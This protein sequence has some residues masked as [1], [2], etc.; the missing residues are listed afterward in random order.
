VGV[1]NVPGRSRLASLVVATAGLVLAVV[2]AVLMSQGGG[3]QASAHIPPGTDTPTVTGAPPTDHPGLDFSI[4][5]NTDGS[6]ATGDQRPDGLGDPRGDDCVSFSKLLITAT[7]AAVAKCNVPP[8]ATFTVSVYVTNLGGV[9]NYAGYDAR[10]NFAGVTTVGS[11]DP[12]V[13]PDCDLALTNVQPDHVI[14]G[15][16]INPP[17]VNDS[18]HVGRIATVT[19]NCAADGTITMVHGNGLTTLTQAFPTPPSD[20]HSELGATSETLSINCDAPTLTP[21]NTPT[22]TNTPVTPTNTPTPTNTSQF[23]NTPTNTFT[24]TA[25]QTPFPEISL[26]AK[27]DRVTCDP[28][29]PPAKKPARCTVPV[30]ATPK[31]A[32]FQIVVDA[33]HIPGGYGG[34]NSEVIFGGLTL[35]GRSCLEEVV[36]PD[37]FL[38]SQVAA[39]TPHSKSHKS[40]TDIFAPFALSTYVGPLVRMDVH[41]PHEGQYK[42]VLPAFV[43]PAGTTTPFRPQAAAY[44]NANDT[45][46]PVSTVGVEPLDLNGDGVAETTPQFPIAD[47]L[48]VN[49][50]VFPTA[51]PSDTPTVTPTPTLTSTPTST[52][53]DGPCPVATATNTSPPPQPTNTPTATRTFTPTPLCCESETVE[54]TVPGKVTTDTEGDGATGS[55]QVETS[56]T[57]TSEG[58]VTINEKSIVLPDP[59]GFSLFGQQV[60]I[61]APQGTVA[62]PLIIVF[63][64]DVSVVPSGLGPNNIAVF[65]AATLVPACSGTPNTASPDPCVMSRL[66]LTGAQAG[67][68]QITVLSSSASSWNFGFSEGGGSGDSNCD[69]QVN[70][71]DALLDLQKSA[72]LIDSLPCEENADV[73]GDGVVDALDALLVLQLDAGLIDSLP[74][75]AAGKASAWSGFARLALLARRY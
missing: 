9:P 37:R 36:W 71:I 57:T 1:L 10:L 35:N 13:W 14:F 63:L 40:R 8:D 56:V 25:T 2:F 64:L 15:C 51:T 5:V 43:P 23:T 11:P 47:T 24:A 52:P 50:V 42:V 46:V 55:D 61:S 29:T 72:G 19:F 26:F 38:C 41:C 60:N 48:L 74:A 69:G 75:G 39:A 27:G 7:P 21:T 18:T 33:N 12:N 45:P 32:E 44:F 67:D 22:A 28:P 70:A 62:R 4:G 68:I 16:F 53:C 59:A 3:E 54:L 17:G 30:E 73:N 31:N 20:I 34:F 49:C 58:Q 66:L 6:T 65:K